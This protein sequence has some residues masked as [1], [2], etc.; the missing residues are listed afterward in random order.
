MKWTIQPIGFPNVY[1]TQDSTAESIKKTN[2]KAQAFK[3]GIESA[4]WAICDKLNLISGTFKKEWNV[5]PIWGEEKVLKIAGKGL[6]LY[7]LITQLSQA[8][9]NQNMEFSHASLLSVMS[10]EEASEAIELLEDMRMVE[11][12]WE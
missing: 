1:L 6:R 5:E 9:F 8:G 11:S 12:H 2:D 7:A 3:I 10:D 4:A